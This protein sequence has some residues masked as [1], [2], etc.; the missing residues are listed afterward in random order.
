MAAVIFP[1]AWCWNR[2]TNG[3]EANVYQKQIKGLSL[4]FIFPFRL[5]RE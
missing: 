4:Y 1:V 2:V 5:V 3:V